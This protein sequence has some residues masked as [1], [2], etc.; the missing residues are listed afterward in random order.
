MKKAV[1]PGTF[2]PITNG[3]LDVIR[4]ALS[5]FDKVVIGIACTRDKPLLFD[6]EERVRL[7]REATKDLERVE[8]EKFDGLLTDYLERRGSKIIIRGLR[9]VTDFDYEFQMA[10]MNRKLSPDIETVFLTPSEEYSF[11]SSSLV[12]EIASRG[13]DVTEFVPPIVEKALR[14]KFSE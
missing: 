2:D 8:V 4:R 9:A 1:Y 7:V 11:L 5:L 14:D 10:L 3:H 13:G 6:S 12:K